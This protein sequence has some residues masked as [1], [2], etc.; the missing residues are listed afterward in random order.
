MAKRLIIRGGSLFIVVSIFLSLILVTNVKATVVP[1]NPTGGVSQGSSIFPYT[2]AELDN[3][4]TQMA[5]TGALYFRVDVDWA[6]V[7]AGGPSSYNWYNPDRIINKA[8]SFGFKVIALINRAPDWA[9]GSNPPYYLPLNSTDFGNFSYQ[10]A[11][12]YMPLGV[13]VFELWNENNLSAGDDVVA[14]TNNIL[15]PGYINIKQRGSELG[16]PSTVLTGGVGPATTDGIHLSMHDYVAG[17]Y[18]N[19]GKGYFDALAVHPYCWPADPTVM[20]SGSWFLK[21]MDLFSIM[22]SNGDGN[23]KIWGT[24]VG[25]PNGSDLQSVTEAQTADYLTKAYNLWRSW[26]FA[27]PLLW[28]NPRD[29]GTN[30]ADTEQNFGLLHYDWSQKPAYTNFVN[31]MSQ[32]PTPTSPGSLFSD[33]FESGSASNWTIVNG[34]WSVVTD[35]TKVYNQLNTSGEGLLYAASSLWTNYTVQ[36]DLKLYTSGATGI[37]A[38]YMDSNNYYMF[39]LNTSLGQVELYKKVAGTFTLL[40]ATPMTINLNT[41]YTLK[42]V[43]NGS[44]ITGYVNGTQQVYATDS[45][46]ISGYV[47]ART[48]SQSASIDNIVVSGILSSDNFESGSSSNWTL[49][50]GSWSV[51]VDGTNVF[52]QS[53]MSGEGLEYS[54]STWWTDYTVQGD[55]KLY[56]TDTSS[57]ATGIIARYTDNN[58]YYMLRLNSGLGQVQLYKKVGGTFTLLQAAPM[59]INTNAWYTL[60]LVLSGS[61][62]TGYVNEVQQVSVADSSL[63]SGCIGARTFNQSASIDNIIVN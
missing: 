33:D 35:G 6:Y 5:A 24:E 46:F 8:I 52:K 39:R 10:V 17:I 58:N 28:Y 4:M 41:W 23:K 7:Q 11:S 9:N 47:G 22:Q 55:L 56:N 59:A 60:K 37:V 26:S 32:T 44:S 19:G 43:L 13:D 51:A 36:E 61:E 29:T 63:T 50:N 49:V 62:I 2:D 53:S 30:L 42:L 16:K 14:Y 45:S 21:T 34:S 31:A 12:R 20:T 15:K 27:G 48:Y 40:K 54:G 38:R 1:W 25:W 18:A 57:T 3:L